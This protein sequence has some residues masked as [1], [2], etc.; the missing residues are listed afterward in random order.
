MGVTY[1]TIGT[2]HFRPVCSLM[3]SSLLTSSLFEDGFLGAKRG[4][5]WSSARWFNFIANGRII[6]PKVQYLLCS[7]FQAS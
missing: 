3:T 5:V 6:I 1:E 4:T 2:D 7:M